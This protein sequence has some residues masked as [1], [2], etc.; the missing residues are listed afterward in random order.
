MPK[1]PGLG[2]FHALCC[3]LI[4]VSSLN[5]GSDFSTFSALTSIFALG[6]AAITWWAQSTRDAL[7]TC[8]GPGFVFRVNVVSPVLVLPGL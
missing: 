5:V 1:H 6:G 2:T 7:P 8:R 3:A 4:M